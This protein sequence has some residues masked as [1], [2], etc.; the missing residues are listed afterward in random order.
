[1]KKFASSIWVLAALMIVSCQKEPGEGV[2]GNKTRPEI[3]SGFHWKNT[4]DISMNVSMPVVDAA[5]DFAVIRVYSSPM[6]LEKNVV[7]KGLVTPS[8]PSFRTA[9]TIP[10][11]VDSV[12]VQTTLPDGSV[13][14]R[15][16]GVSASD[17]TVS[18]AAMQLASSAPP[19]MVLPAPA[20][21]SAMVD[22]P[23][24]AQKGESDFDARAVIDRTP[25][26]MYQLGASWAEYATDAYLIPAGA[27]ITDNISL[28]GDFSPYRNPILYV[29]GTLK[30]STLQI[31]PATLAVL[32]GG[33]VTIGNLTARN[34]GKK[35][36]PLVYV[37]AGG[38]LRVKNSNLS[39]KSTVNCGTMIVEDELL[40]NNQ[41]EFFNVAGAMFQVHELKYSGSGTLYNDG[42]I[43]AD[44]FETDSSVTVW[45]Y[46]NGS[47]EIEDYEMEAGNRVYQQGHARIKELKSR[48][49]FYVDC[50]TYVEEIEKADAGAKFFLASDACL[51]V[52]KS[53]FNNTEIELAAGS[54]LLVKNYNTSD[55]GDGNMV[56]SLASTEDRMPVVKFERAVCHDGKK[57]KFL[58][59]MEVVYDYSSQSEKYRID[60]DKYFKKG[61]VLREKQVAN[62]PASECNGGKGAIEQI[63]EPKPEYIDVTGAD[64]TFCFEDNWPWTGDYDM[65][66]IVVRMSIDRHQTTLGQVKSIR[67]NWEPLATGSA[68]SLAFAVQ[69]DGIPSSQVASVETTNTAFG[70][71]PFAASGLEDGNE[72]AVIPLFNSVKEVFNVASAYINT[73]KGAQSAVT[74]E[75][76]TTVTFTQ[77]VDASA[78]LESKL[79]AFIVVNPGKSVTYERTTEVHMAGYKPTKYAEV[80]GRNT[81][82]EAEPYKYFVTRGNGMRN[83][84]M[85]WGLMIPG[86]F[87]HPS[88]WSDIR[89]AYE[90]FNIWAASGGSQHTEWYKEDVDTNLLF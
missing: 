9:F 79:N 85:M 5:V 74:T 90:F 51:E 17:I 84:G 41:M 23:R 28:D 53:G 45:N 62:I 55:S 42:A 8:D 72:Y 6:L 56:K 11:G 71:G 89:D 78:V 87:R 1:M 46:T 21:K 40:L 13:D 59:P 52:V 31:G 27:V 64:Y 34:T 66:D 86:T 60:D 4:K 61:A 26:S 32:P 37:F 65:N 68:N 83:N 63:P 18:G 29:A 75:Y 2:D 30:L 88:E 24:I 19:R 25:A 81:V 15:P 43:A 67:I 48:G 12:F 47:L 58:G 20:E 35:E 70:A 38:E 69:L 80:T 39:G 77:P 14:V 10:A 82:T 36:Q 33:K 7:A 3:P 49:K 50:Y 76:A 57:T 16:V 22:Y 73:K 44:D 54:L